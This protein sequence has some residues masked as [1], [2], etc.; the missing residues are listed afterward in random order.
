MFP[1]FKLDQLSNSCFFRT[2][3]PPKYLQPLRPT[4]SWPRPTYTVL[5]PG[6]SDIDT[7]ETMDF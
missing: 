5:S 3:Y 6:N 7:K 1:P 2:D 4:C